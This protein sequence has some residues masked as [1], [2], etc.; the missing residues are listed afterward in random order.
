M[1]EQ[2]LFIKIYLRRL[3]FLLIAIFSSLQQSRGKSIDYGERV[4]LGALSTEMLINSEYPE[5]ADHIR[6]DQPY[7]TADFTLDGPG[8]LNVSTFGGDIRVNRSPDQDQ[9]HVHVELYVNRGFALWSSSKS[10]DNYLITILK[11]GNEIT[12]SVEQKKRDGGFWGGGNMGFTFVITVPQN[13]SGNLNTAGGDIEIEGVKGNQVLKTAGGHIS[14]SGIEGQVIAQNAGGNISL[15]GIDGVIRADN[16]GGNIDIDSSRGSINARSVGGHV[17]V[18]HSNGEVRIK[19]AAGDVTARHITGTLLVKSQVGNIDV[20]M[21]AVDQGVSLETSVGNISAK[22]PGN[23][24]YDLV[25][26]ARDVNME[27]KNEFKGQQRTGKLEGQFKEGGV[28][29]NM[30]SNTGHVSLNFD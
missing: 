29:V 17:R 7:R 23:T 2:Q 4:N 10:M 1:H 14:A 3:L 26:N 19:S 5:K 6:T 9:D 27:R 13:I 21:D 11:R 28:P 30:K 12:A 16:K 24:G 20:S 25:L 15:S 8:V 18:D 22:L